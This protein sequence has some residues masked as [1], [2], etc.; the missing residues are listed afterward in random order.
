MGRHGI[1][2]FGLGRAGMIHLG[3]IMANH[4]C[5]LLYVV[6]LNLDKVQEVLKMYNLDDVK[7]AT[8]DQAE[9]IFQDP[10]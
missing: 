2:V 9:N 4:R 1:V 8:P 10:G 7:A 6:D 5:R 3:N